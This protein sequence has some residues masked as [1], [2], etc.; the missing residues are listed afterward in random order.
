MGYWQWDFIT[1]LVSCRAARASL[2]TVVSRS[3]Q[4]TREVCRWRIGN[5]GNYCIAVQA[6]TALRS[7]FA[8][9]SVHDSSSSSVQECEVVEVKN[10]CPFRQRTGVT[11]KG[12]PR[13]SYMLADP[14]PR[15]RV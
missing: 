3:Y 12:N 15:Q 5:R 8:G 1:V 9:M 11:K 7:A 13:M 14:G 4:G 6:L 10:T 2:T